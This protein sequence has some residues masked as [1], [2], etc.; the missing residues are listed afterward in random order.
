MDTMSQLRHNRNIFFTRSESYYQKDKRILSS[1]KSYHIGRFFS[2]IG[3]GVLV[4][5]LL[6][7]F[8]FSEE[9]KS[10]TPVITISVS[11]IG[12]VILLIG[13]CFLAVSVYK[14]QK[15]IINADKSDTNATVCT[16]G[17]STV[18]EIIATPHESVQNNTIDA[19]ITINR[20][21]D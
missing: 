7:K 4:F 9:T 13:I 8:I 11:T 16:S 19:S 18:T 6:C 12:G 14:S 5:G 3:S 21:N 20:T 17:Q 10:E 1:H 2:L 15:S